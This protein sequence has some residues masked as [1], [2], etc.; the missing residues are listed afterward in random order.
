MANRSYLYSYYSK[1]DKKYR[2]LSEQNYDIPLVHLILVGIE[3]E[4]CN[5][6]LWEVDSAIAIRGQAASARELLL[7]FFDWL[8]PQL[9]QEFSEQVA[10]VKEIL[11]KE[12][13]QGTHYHLEPGEVYE[14]MGLSVEEMNL[15]ALEDAAE[16]ALIC[17]VIKEL[18]AV[19]GSTIA[20]TD[21]ELLKRI[22]DNWQVELG[23]YFSE[24]LYYHFKL[25]D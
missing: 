10:E 14:L 20:D 21:N 13:R 23:L 2:D 9:G 22:P 11:L 19:E 8:T 4:V 1:A 3:T 17:Q 6:A 12:N 16:A 18:M 25:D 7:R 24:V 15:Q 5:S